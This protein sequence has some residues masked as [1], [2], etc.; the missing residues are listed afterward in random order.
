M[1]N[2]HIKKKTSFL[3]YFYGQ[4]Q[5]YNIPIIFVHEAIIIMTQIFFSVTTLP[6]KMS[7]QQNNVKVQINVLSTSK[8]LKDL[9][10]H[11]MKAVI[12]MYEISVVNSV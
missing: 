8:L 9:L 11:L 7:T 2:S 4:I 5:Y 3:S 12:Y 6:H 10:V 1:H